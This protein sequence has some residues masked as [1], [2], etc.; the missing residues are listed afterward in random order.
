[1][2]SYL[3]KVEKGDKKRD[4]DTYVCVI[5]FSTIYHLMNVYGFT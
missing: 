3:P 4:D 5:E 1:V 2:K